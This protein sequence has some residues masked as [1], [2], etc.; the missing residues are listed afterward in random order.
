MWAEVEVRHPEAV[1]TL[2][3]ET[4]RLRERGPRAYVGDVPGAALCRA[5]ALPL[6]FDFGWEALGFEK[7]DRLIEWRD[8]VDVCLAWGWKAASPHCRPECSRCGKVA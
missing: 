4:D 2:A 7:C 3:D 8:F 6:L 5:C 1:T